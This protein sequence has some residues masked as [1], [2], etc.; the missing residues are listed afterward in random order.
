MTVVGPT[1]TSLSSSGP[2]W[3]LQRLSGDVREEHNLLEISA[4]KIPREN[5]LSAHRS[6]HPEE[7]VGDVSDTWELSCVNAWQAMGMQRR[8]ERG[9]SAEMQSKEEGEEPTEEHVQEPTGWEPSP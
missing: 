2:A 7:R 3:Y 6:Q 4:W 5:S 9:Q 1:W 8:E